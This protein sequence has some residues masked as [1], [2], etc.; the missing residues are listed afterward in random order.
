MGAYGVGNICNANYESPVGVDSV[1][2]FHPLL[3]ECFTTNITFCKNGC[4]VNGF[5]E[6]RNGW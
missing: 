2:W 4:L 3:W 5:E 6:Q 1:L